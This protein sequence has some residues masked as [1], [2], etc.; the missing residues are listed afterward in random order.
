MRVKGEAAQGYF[1]DGEI[2]LNDTLRRDEALMVLAHEIGHAWHFSVQPKPDEISDF[3]A[4]G[5]AEWVSF[6]LMKRAGLTEYCF[7][8]KKNPDPLYG[9]AFR[10]YQAIEEEFGTKAVLDIMKY[11]LD[12]DGHKRPISFLPQSHQRSDLGLGFQQ[13]PN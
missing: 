8:L 6:R 12:Q 5:F 1:E 7:R 2:V 3:L 4:E 13:A 11:W 9:G 10:W